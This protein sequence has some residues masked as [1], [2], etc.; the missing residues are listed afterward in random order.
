MPYGT[1]KTRHFNTELAFANEKVKDVLQKLISAYA[2][3]NGVEGRTH[4]N[5]D[6]VMAYAMRQNHFKQFCCQWDA[7]EQT[8]DGRKFAGC[9]ASFVADCVKKI[10]E[11]MKASGVQLVRLKK[12]LRVDIDSDDE[13]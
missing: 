7:R 4:P 8:K 10:K 9:L 13:E 1:Y 11:S 12:R 3:V 5:F 2:L 6:D